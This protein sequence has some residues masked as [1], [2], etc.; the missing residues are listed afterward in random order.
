MFS[1]AINVTKVI[2]NFSTST[3]DVIPVEL[4]LLDDNIVEPTDFYQLT[5]VNISGP[6]VVVG[7]M[8]TTLIIVNDDD[9]IIGEDN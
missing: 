9:E 1:A 4:Q 3:D 7:D 2:V 8:N 5:I 6:N